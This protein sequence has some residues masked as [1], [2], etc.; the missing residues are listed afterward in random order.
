MRPQYLGRSYHLHTGVPTL[1]QANDHVGETGRAVAG[2]PTRSLEQFPLSRVYNMG[3]TLRSPAPV[4][5]HVARERHACYTENHVSVA[6]GPK[7][8]FNLLDK[9]GL[10][11][12]KNLYQMAA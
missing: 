5:E 1:W 10:Q 8:A 9:N 2:P 3:V 11:L 7:N 6:E 12:R 4:T